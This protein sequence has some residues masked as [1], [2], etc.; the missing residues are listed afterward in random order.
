MCTKQHTHVKARFK[1]PMCTSYEWLLC[2][3]NNFSPDHS[4]NANVG[5]SLEITSSFEL[6]ICKLWN[7]T[8]GINCLKVLVMFGLCTEKLP[9][10]TPT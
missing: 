8:R 10:I 5:P 2:I 7:F 1:T 6:H 3:T 9:R 4:L